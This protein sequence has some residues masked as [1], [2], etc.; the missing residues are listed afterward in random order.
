ME[1]YEFLKKG[2]WLMVP[3]VTASVVA[4]AVFLERLWSTRRSGVL[5][6]DFVRGV[7]KRVKSQDLTTARAMCGNSAT[8]ISRII[9]SALSHFRQPRSVIK[10]AMEEAGQ[11]EV[12]GLQRYTMVLGVVATLSPLM[13]LLGT[14]TGM[15][16]TFQDIK[17]KAEPTV[18]EMAR[19]IEQALITTAAGL[20]VA[21][22][23]F[24]A[25]KFLQA[26][27]EKYAIQMEE[28]SL[29][30]LDALAERGPAPAATTVPEQQTSAPTEGNP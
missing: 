11:L 29:Q 16:I 1:L 5:P 10:E 22:I 23:A 15:I 9:E 19:G 14:V 2:G 12:A 6:Y 18:Q 7:L 17:R 26:R 24:L 27:N 13:G 28:T 21:I 20:T 3:I 25:L 4:V 30:V 8:R